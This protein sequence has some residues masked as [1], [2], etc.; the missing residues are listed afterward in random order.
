MNTTRKVGRPRKETPTVIFNYRMDA[1]LHEWVN[2]VR[3]SKSMTQFIND[4][5]RERA[6]L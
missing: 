4:I 1:D 3:G 2:S 5:I 6:G